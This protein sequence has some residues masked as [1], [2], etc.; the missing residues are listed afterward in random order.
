MVL[1]TRWWSG[2]TTCPV[3]GCVVS[4]SDFPGV[5]MSWRWSLRTDVS[6]TPLDGAHQQ[7]EARPGV[8]SVLPADVPPIPLPAAHYGLVGDPGA[9]H[10]L[11]VAVDRAVAYRDARVA[12]AV[13]IKR[14]LLP[15]FTGF[16]SM[17]SSWS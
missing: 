2:F 4:A 17:D 15:A 1:P 5:G 10:P 9:L 6:G 11:F 13:T 14:L 8:V 3:L 16:P 7:V 12:A